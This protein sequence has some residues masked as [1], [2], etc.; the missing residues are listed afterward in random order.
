MLVDIKTPLHDGQ[1]ILKLSDNE[2]LD[3]ERQRASI[4]RIRLPLRPPRLVQCP[5]ALDHHRPG[6]RTVAESQA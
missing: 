3:D 5:V 4:L 6:A 1:G 2:S